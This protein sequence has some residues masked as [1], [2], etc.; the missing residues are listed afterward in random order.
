MN[1]RNKNLKSKWWTK[2]HPLL[3]EKIWWTLVY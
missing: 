1:Q 3:D 2:F